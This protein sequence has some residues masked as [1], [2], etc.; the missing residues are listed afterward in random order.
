MKRD[1]SH[2]IILKDEKHWDEWK[3]QTV[4]TIFAHGC[5]NI[6]SPYIPTVADDILLFKEQQNFMFGVL[7]H[8]IRTPMGKHFVR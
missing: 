7:I 6:L 4:A 8:I 2:Y 5:E 3:R 1:K